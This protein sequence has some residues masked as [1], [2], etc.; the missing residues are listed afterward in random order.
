MTEAPSTIQPTAE[1]ETQS[2]TQMFTIEEFVRLYDT[3]GPFE[4]IDGERIPMS[5][6]VFGPNEVAKILFLALSA[7]EQTTRLGEAFFETAF[8]LPGELSSNWVKGSRTP[9][10]MFIRAERLAQYRATTLDFRERPLMLVPDLVVEIIS[11]TDK[12]ADVNRKVIK[13]RQD[14]VRLIW[15]VDPQA[16]TVMVYMADSNQQTLLSGEILLTGSDVMPG[17]EVV[18]ATLF[19]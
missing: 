8:V 6:S 1:S 17:F 11:P 12:F 13:Y 10:L 5:P 18:I 15:L 2:T 19:V 14:G 9:D 3:E 16:K 4:I 7:Y